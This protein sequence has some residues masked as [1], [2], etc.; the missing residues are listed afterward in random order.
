VAIF[1]GIDEEAGPQLY[2]CDPAGHYAGYRVRFT[3]FPK[4]D[5]IP[6]EIVQVK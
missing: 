2:Q 6:F 3:I 1:F 4:T 5:I